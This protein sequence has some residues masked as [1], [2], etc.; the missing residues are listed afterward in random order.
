M[1]VAKVGSIDGG[2]SKTYA[3]WQGMS[4]AVS[5]SISIIQMLLMCSIPA[6]MSCDIEAWLPVGS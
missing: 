5:A 6:L 3:Q 2:R 4:H 1:N